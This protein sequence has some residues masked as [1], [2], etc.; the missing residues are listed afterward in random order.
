VSVR[1][2]V[3]GD[4]RRFTDAE[5]TDFEGGGWTVGSAVE[6]LIRRNP[7]LDSAM[8][9]AQGRL[10]YAMVL[11]LCGRPATWPQDR[12]TAI[13]DGGELLVTRFHSGG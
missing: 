2:R 11:R 13:E 6:E 10:Q 1:I 8:F 7:G 5:S 4:L 12:D 9:D 3:L